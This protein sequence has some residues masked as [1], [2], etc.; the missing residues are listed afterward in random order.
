MK[1]IALLAAGVAVVSASPAFAQSGGDTDST[2]FDVTATVQDTCLIEDAGDV[3]FGDIELED[4]NVPG[5]D[6]L[7]LNNGSQEGSTQDIWVSCNYAAK[8]T[9]SSDNDGLFNSSGSSLVAN[10]PDDFTDTIH[11]RIELTSPDGNFPFLRLSTN[12]GGDSASV[13]AGGAFHDQ[14]SMRVYIDADGTSKRPVAGSYSDTATIEVG[15][16]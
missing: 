12:L 4:S 3:P 6:S 10:D 7:T 5:P 14:A 2:S 9:A 15:P 1:K 8:I 16:A 13:T 11:Y